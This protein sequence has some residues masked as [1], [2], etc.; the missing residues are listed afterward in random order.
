[1]EIIAISWYVECIFWSVTGVLMMRVRCHYIAT[2]YFLVLRIENYEH[3]DGFVG[4]RRACKSSAVV[5]H[6]CNHFKK[7]GVAK[8]FSGGG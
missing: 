2:F 7:A 8:R 6:M 5:Y 1:M 3:R 4:N